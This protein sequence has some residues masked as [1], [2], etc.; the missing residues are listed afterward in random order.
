VRTNVNRPD[1]EWEGLPALRKVLEG[2]S[3]TSENYQT[4]IHEFVAERV[5]RILQ[6]SGI[7]IDNGAAILR[8]VPEL[9]PDA[10]IDDLDALSASI[11]GERARLEHFSKGIARVLNS[12][13]RAAY[14]I[15]SYLATSFEAAPPDGAIA[16]RVGQL[17]SA[18]DALLLT[19]EARSWAYLTAFNPRG[20]R[21]SMDENRRRMERLTADVEKAGHT[22]FRGQGV[23]DRHDWQP[24]ESLLVLGITEDDAVALGGRY[25]QHAIV[26]GEMGE[27]A[28]LL[29]CDFS[30]LE[31]SGT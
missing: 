17:C 11:E 7:A 1:R 9:G 20:S 23:P 10:V 4:S 26:A 29:W 12:V 19:H 28:R 24:E 25:E 18:L 31:P 3:P 15:P 8:R 21:L 5:V 6:A 13:R 2:R 14:F 27:P 16:I 30:H 22:Y